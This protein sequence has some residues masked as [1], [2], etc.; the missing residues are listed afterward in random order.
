MGPQH[1]L[2]DSFCTD[3]TGVKSLHHLNLPSLFATPFDFSRSCSIKT[4]FLKSRFCDDSITSRD[5]DAT[6]NR[7]NH[8]GTRI[9]IPIEPIVP[10]KHAVV[11]CPPRPVFPTGFF[12]VAFFSFER[13]FAERH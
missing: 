5:R 3:K 8:F 13:L 11:G 4:F 10:P 9:A 2:M 12:R 1:C 6:K 7:E